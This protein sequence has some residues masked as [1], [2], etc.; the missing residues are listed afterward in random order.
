MDAEEATVT[1][2]AI[3]VF[4]TELKAQG[5]KKIGCYVAH[6]RYNSYNYES[7]RDLF[8]FTWI[9]RYGSNDGTIAG[10]TKP[11]YECDLW[12]YTSTGKVSGISGNVDLNVL[13][14]DEKPIEWFLNLK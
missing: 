14:N 9:P 3:R 6:N 2:A 4:A 11:A 1:N 10:A 7:V 5:A 8:D 12:Q 13:M